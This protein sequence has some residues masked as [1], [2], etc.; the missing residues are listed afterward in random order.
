MYLFIYDDIINAA[1]L[2]A[3]IQGVFV[4]IL[5]RKQTVYTN[6]GYAIT[7][8]IFNFKLTISRSPI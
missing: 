3:L 1:T 6:Y 8:R 5:I 7:L 4:G 2:N